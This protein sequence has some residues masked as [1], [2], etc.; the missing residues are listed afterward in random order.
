VYPPG[1]DT[2]LVDVKGRKFPYG[3]AG[4]G[5]YWEN[6]VTLAD[7]KSLHRWQEVFGRGFEA[8]IVFAYWL[9][10]DPDRWPTLH[11]HPFADRHYAFY[12]VPLATYCDRARERSA[13]WQTVAMPAKAFQEAAHPVAQM[14][15][16]A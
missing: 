8:L 11:V 1:G 10:G 2:W 9:Q 7:L 14:I 5:R 16:P 3:R 4:G 13:R 6:W 15:E 12:G